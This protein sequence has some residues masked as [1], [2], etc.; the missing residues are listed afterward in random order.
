MGPGFGA[1]I[2]RT[3]FCGLLFF[4]ALALGLGFGAGYGCKGCNYR[5]HIEMR[6]VDAK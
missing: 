1:E 5:P 4:V 2:G 3:L 6:K